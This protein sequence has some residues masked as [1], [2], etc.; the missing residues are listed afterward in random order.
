MQIQPVRTGNSMIQNLNFLA[1]RN[2]CS[3]ELIHTVE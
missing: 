2:V 3:E 1:I